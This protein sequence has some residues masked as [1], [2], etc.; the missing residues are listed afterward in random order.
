MSKTRNI[1]LGAAAVTVGAVTF[2]KSMQQ[3]LIDA[4][5]DRAPK[6]V[7]K[8]YNQM[9]LEAFRGNLRGVEITDD[10]L[11][12]LFDIKYNKLAKKQ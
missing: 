2:H 11:D 7:K 5:P 10:F 9:M 1:T 3:Q 8:A 4:Y 6:L 12:R